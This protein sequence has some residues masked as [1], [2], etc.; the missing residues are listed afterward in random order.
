MNL[1]DKAFHIAVSCLRSNYR[2]SGIYAGKHHFNDYWARD[3]FFASLG[4]M[5]LGDYDIVKKNISLFL[6]NQK[7][8]GELPIRIGASTFEIGFKTLGVRIPF[9]E[10]PRFSQDKGKHNSVDQG[11]L[12]VIA[13]YEYFRK[14]KDYSFL[15]ENIAKLELA[16]KLNLTMD[17]DNDFLIEEKEYGNWA[18]SLKKSGKVLYSNVCHAHSLYCLSELFSALKNDSKKTEYSILYN[19]A[20]EKIN[21]SFWLSDYYADWFDDKTYDFF[22][23]DGNIL[24]ILWDIADKKKTKKII[25]TI[26][27]IKINYTVPCLT[28]Y[29]RY[30]IKHCSLF[31]RLVGLGDYHN[32][33]SWLWLGCVYSAALMHVGMKKEALAILEKI[34]SIIVRDNTVYEVFEKNGQPVRRFLYKSELNFAWSSGLFIY[35]YSNIRKDIK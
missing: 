35:G 17:I 26:K 18:D 16:I 5:S 34:S 1:I 3:S 25:D 11:S 2:E 24:A 32:E 23:T 21:A 19:K 15:Q 4:A 8:S 14:T 6:K 30:P 12:L 20:K 28:N 13:F 27:K 22:S 9:K 10:V 31:M 7:K 33:L 29:P